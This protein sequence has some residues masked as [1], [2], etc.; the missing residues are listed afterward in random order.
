[1]SVFTNFLR[2]LVLTVVFCALAPLLFFGLV[3]GVAT[4][5]GYLPGLANLSGAIADGIMAFL[6]TFGSGTPIWGIGII[7]LTC[8]FVGVL[9]DIYVHYRYLI[10]HTD[11]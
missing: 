9:F 8:S 4:L 10:L 6:T 1:M 3:L 11:S 7:C 2:S 5:I